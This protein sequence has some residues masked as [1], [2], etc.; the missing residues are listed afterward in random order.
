VDAESNDDTVE[1]I[2]QTDSPVK[3][4]QQKKKGLS[5]GRN[6]GI[7]AANSDWIAFLDGDDERLPHLIKNQ[8][9]LLQNNPHLVWTGANFWKHCCT[10][11]AREAATSPEKL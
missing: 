9:N 11:N 10:T 1:I 5:A 4:I 2:K 7:E 3:L 8:T 6:E